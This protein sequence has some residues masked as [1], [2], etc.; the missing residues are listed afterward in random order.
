MKFSVAIAEGLRFYIEIVTQYKDLNLR[1][2]SKRV[3]KEEMR[4]VNT[5]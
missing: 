1:N 2:F 3:L 4:N 5:T